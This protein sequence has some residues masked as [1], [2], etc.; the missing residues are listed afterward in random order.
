MGTQLLQ[1]TEAFGTGSGIAYKSLNWLQIQLHTHQSIPVASG[2]PLPQHQVHCRSCTSSQL[3]LWWQT[4]VFSSLW[5]CFVAAKHL[6][7]TLSSC[8]TPKLSTAVSKRGKETNNIP[9]HSI[10][11]KAQSEVIKPKPQFC[12]SMQ[13]QVV[14]AGNVIPIKS[15]FLFHCLCST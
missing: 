3:T 8:F 15:P 7:A 1:S 12:R 5:K 14:V 2:M 6:Q 13:G 9:H 11:W 4:P 10:A